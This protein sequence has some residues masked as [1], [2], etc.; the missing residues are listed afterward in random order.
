MFAAF[1][2]GFF[3]GWMADYLGVP[4]PVLGVGVYDLVARRRLHRAYVLGAAWILIAVHR[5][6]ALRVAVVEGCVAPHTG[7]LGDRSDPQVW[8]AIVAFDY[9]KYREFDGH[10]S[11]RALCQ[12]PA[13]VRP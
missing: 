7:A 13:S 9:L 8:A 3:G 12:Q 6:V 2:D 5:R 4:L 11:L 10:A 1:G